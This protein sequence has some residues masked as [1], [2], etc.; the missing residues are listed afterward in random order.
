MTR[1][2]WQAGGRCP[3]G[4]QRHHLVPLEIANRRQFAALFA[5]LEGE[6]LRLGQFAHN[7]LHL[8]AREDVA[9]ELGHALH[10][11]PHPAYTD[12]VAARIEAIRGSARLESPADHWA[13]INRIDTLQRALRR[14]LTDR[15]GQHLWLNRRDPMRIFADRAYLDSAIDAMFG[16]N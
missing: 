14:A 13:V 4:F 15:H 2:R 11:G 1:R 12:V 16:E 8:P 6:G 7:G 9:A 10:R 5:A 3:A